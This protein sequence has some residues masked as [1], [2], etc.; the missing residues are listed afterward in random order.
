MPTETDSTSSTAKHQQHLVCITKHADALCSIGWICAAASGCM[1]RAAVAH[2]GSN[3]Q[4][5][6]L[7]IADLTTRTYGR[8]MFG[9]SSLPQLSMLKLLFTYQSASSPSYKQRRHSVKYLYH[10]LLNL[11]MHTTSEYVHK[12]QCGRLSAVGTDHMHTHTWCTLTG[13]SMCTMHVYSEEVVSSGLPLQA[14][15]HF[16]FVRIGCIGMVC[17]TELVISAYLQADSNQ[18]NRGRCEVLHILMQCL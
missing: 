7:L 5:H 2:S 4:W 13:C 12:H 10:T 11:Q 8:H 6:P 16:L 14:M 3:I 15:E 17:A 9:M 1:E 18:V